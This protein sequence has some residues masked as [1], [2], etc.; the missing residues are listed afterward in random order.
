[1]PTTKNLRMSAQPDKFK[2]YG[3][4]DV[5]VT[6]KRENMVEDSEEH[7]MEAPLPSA[8]YRAWALGSGEF[9]MHRRGKQ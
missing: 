3:I 9:D 7:M 8:V 2:S 4:N 1:M 6:K 5:R